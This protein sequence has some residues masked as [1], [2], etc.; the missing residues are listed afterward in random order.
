MNTEIAFADAP[1]VLCVDDDPNFISGLHR[2]FRKYVV[3]FAS[4]YNA[5]Q[6]FRR[7]TNRKP[8]LV[9]CDVKMPGVQG[10]E[11]LS[12]MRNNQSVH[13]IPLII[14]TGNGGP[15]ARAEAID[16]GASG[17]LEKPVSPEELASEV[18]RFIPLQRRDD[19]LSEMKQ[20]QT[21]G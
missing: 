6:A 19:R 3:R 5:I 8:D 2:Y 11:M 20:Q 21:R 14:L 16:A 15:H 4:C 10:I 13:D 9:I 18:Q 12:W 17:F 7:I 1:W